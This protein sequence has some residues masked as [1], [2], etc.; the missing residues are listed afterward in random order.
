[1][2][3]RSEEKHSDK[4]REAVPLGTQTFPTL[5]DLF[6]R[7]PFSFIR[8]K[9]KILGPRFEAARPFWSHLR[10]VYF[11]HQLG[12]LIQNCLQVP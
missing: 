3:S 9:K 7:G 12:N 2:N 5:S 11:I 1:M 8:R 10:D 6:P 4:I